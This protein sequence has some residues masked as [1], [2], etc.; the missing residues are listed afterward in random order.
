MDSVIK[1]Y[2]HM[3]RELERYVKMEKLIDSCLEREDE[4]RQENKKLKQDL[5]VANL[6]EIEQQ[7]IFQQEIMTVHELIDEIRRNLP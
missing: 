1:K 5:Q 2:E 7:K 4:M 3:D 6:R